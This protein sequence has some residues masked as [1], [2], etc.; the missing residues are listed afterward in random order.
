MGGEERVERQHSQ[1]APDRARARRRGCST[2]A[3]STR[4]A[5]SRAG[6]ST[7]TA[8]WRSSCPPTWSWARAGSTAGGRSCR[9]TTSRCAA[10]PRMRR[11]GRRWSTP[12]AW[13]TSCG[14]RSCGSWTGRAAAAASSR[15]RRWASPTC[16]SSRAGRWRRANLSEVPVVAAALGPGGRAR[17]GARGRLALLG[18]RARHRAAVRG[19]ARRWW[20]PRWGSRRTRK[21]SAARVRRRAPARS[22]T[23]RRTRTTR[24]RSCAAS[25]PICRRTCG[26]RRRC[27]PRRTRASAARRSCVSIVPRERRQP[28]KARRILEAVFDRGSLFEVGASFGRSLITAL[29]APRRAAGGRALLRPEPLRGRADRGRL[30][31]AHALRR[32]VRPVPAAGRELRRP[33]RVRDRHR[34]RAARHDPARHAR[35]GRRLPGKRAV[36]VGAGAQGV[37]RRGRGARPG[38]RAQPALR[39]AV[40]RLGIAADRRAASRPPTG[41]SWRRRTTRSRCAR[42]SRRG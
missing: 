37:R 1:R 16:R 26:R 36:G 30:R 17:R 23:R 35:A 18:D 24:S 38:A 8:S 39:V 4:R 22:T 19:R 32:R 2:P 21:S 15:W 12:S 14:C 20:R 6:A 31:E 34:G 11:S 41:A 27:R 10:A 29:G 9:A 5:R 40:G 33:A 25:S 28:Y 13:R 7:R 3:R 42:R